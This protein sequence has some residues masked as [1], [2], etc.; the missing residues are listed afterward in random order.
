MEKSPQVF[1]ENCVL[2]DWASEGRELVR[3][4]WSVLVR[5]EMSAPPELTGSTA[6]APVQ[7]QRLPSGSAW[8]TPNTLTTTTTTISYLAF[9]TGV[10]PGT[11]SHVTLYNFQRG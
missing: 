6:P 2:L 1:V 9:Y 5:S 8:V 10:P 4:D 7:A 3:C 11:V